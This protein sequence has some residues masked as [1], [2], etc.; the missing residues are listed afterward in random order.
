MPH[1]W[2]EA[3]GQKMNAISNILRQL[4]EIYM[5]FVFVNAILSWFVFGTRNITVRRIYWWTGKVV[6][7]VLN[8]IRR[9]LEPVTRNFGIDISPFILL[10][11]LHILVQ[12]LGP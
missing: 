11:F 10:M 12:M 1:T 3:N 7:P 4:L 6:D 2:V 9:M 8:P 5:I